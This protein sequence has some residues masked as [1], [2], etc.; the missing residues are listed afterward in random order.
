MNSTARLLATGALLAI[1]GCFADTPADV[2]LPGPMQQ[3]TVNALEPSGDR[4][5]EVSALLLG[6]VE[7]TAPKVVVARE[8]E[9][10]FAE[11]VTIDPTVGAPC[12]IAWP[13]R[14]VEWNGSVVEA[15][16]GRAIEI[17]LEPVADLGRTRLR[18]S[19][20]REEAWTRVTIEQ[21]PFTDGMKG[22]VLANAH[23]NAFSDA[24]GRLQSICDGRRDV[25]PAGPPVVLHPWN[26]VV[27]P[28]LPQVKPA[29]YRGPADPPPTAPKSPTGK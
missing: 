19:L 23:R 7:Q 25:E 12:R 10:W 15:E 26:P 13:S 1:A 24:L 16:P 6:D 3:A 11:S 2:P 9:R 28:E 4:A 14:G 22:E 21:W 8:L 27:E 20:D 29:P 18:F 5:V 17:E